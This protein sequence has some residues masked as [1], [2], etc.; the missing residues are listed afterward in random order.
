VG[1]GGFTLRTQIIALLTFVLLSSAVLPATSTLSNAIDGTIAV[2]VDGER[3]VFPDQE[4]II[5]NGHVLVPVRAVFEA[6]GFEVEWEDGSEWGQEIR[7]VT[8]TKFAETNRTVMYSLNLIENTFIK[9]IQVSRQ[10]FVGGSVA[11]LDESIRII[12]DRTMLP[13]QYIEGIGAEFYRYSDDIVHIYSPVIINLSEWGMNDWQLGNMVRNG[14]IPANTTVLYLLENQITDIAPL[15]ELT[16]LRILDM[17][18]N[19]VY[20]ITPLSELN[21]ITWLR[22]SSNWISDVTPL[23]GLYDLRIL[24]LSG[25][26]ISNI[27]PLASLTNL[28]LLR[29]ERNLINDYDELHQLLPNTNIWR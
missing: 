23:S 6:M 17:Y 13:I 21:N 27:M 2:F 5:Y 20:D 1:E 8:L 22:L 28:R 11:I 9:R 19:M 4:P 10:F 18:W 7:R 15:A 24:I 25:N 12:N 14:T 29:I 26:Q 16:N 3:V